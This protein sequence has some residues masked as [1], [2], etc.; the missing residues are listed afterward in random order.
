[1]VKRINNAFKRNI[2]SI[3]HYESA[4]L[5]MFYF[6]HDCVKEDFKRR[7]KARRGKHHAG[8]TAG[9]GSRAGIR[10]RKIKNGR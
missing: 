4:F 7:R 1:M 10:N 5:Q 9:T 8:R 6:D 3:D 2:N